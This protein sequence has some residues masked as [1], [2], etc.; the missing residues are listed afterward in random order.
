[1]ADYEVKEVKE[2]MNDVLTGERVFEYKEKK[3][4]IRFPNNR[5]SQLAD[6]EYSKMF[7]ELMDTNLKTRAEMEEMLE[8]RKI[9]TGADEARVQSLQKSISDEQEKL[10]KSKSEKEAQKHRD[11]IS[12]HRKEVQKIQAK[13]EAYTNN[14]IESKAENAKMGYLIYCVTTY[15][16]TGERVWGTYNDYVD[17]EDSQLLYRATL[18]FLTFAYGMPSSFLEQSPLDGEPQEENGEPDGE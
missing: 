11:N 15:L 5:E 17:E 18:E 2:T 4:K 8:K 6:L 1:M 7:T 10:F 13:K 9:W 3:I 12:K 14:T 16:D